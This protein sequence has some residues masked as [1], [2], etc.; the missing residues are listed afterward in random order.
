VLEESNKSLIRRIITD[1]ER[2][3]NN[4]QDSLKMLN[5]KS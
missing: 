4:W 5:Q 1:E 2:H 3:I